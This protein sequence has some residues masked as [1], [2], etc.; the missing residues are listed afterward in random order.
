MQQIQ[1]NL[2][3]LFV[4]N[5][6]LSEQQFTFRW[7]QLESHYKLE[8]EESVLMSALRV[9]DYFMFTDSDQ[10]ELAGARHLGRLTS[11]FL[12]KEFKFSQVRNE[13]GPVLLA[14]ASLGLFE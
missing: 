9:S 3:G 6:L 12:A 8:L 1:L 11:N 2:A 4:T 13:P 5:P 7:N 14:H 10:Y